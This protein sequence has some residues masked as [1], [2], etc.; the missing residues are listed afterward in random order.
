MWA[1][2]LDVALMEKRFTS[3]LPRAAEI[4]SAREGKPTAVGSVV[5]VIF[6]PLTMRGEIA[7]GSY[8][9]KRILTG[10]MQTCRINR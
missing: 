9:D 6:L 1:S 8:D 10:P 4:I 7:L 5:A 3:T 2:F